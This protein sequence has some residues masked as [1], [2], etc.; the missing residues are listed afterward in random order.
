[1]LGYLN[2]PSPFDEDGWYNTHDVVEVDGPYIRILGRTT[3]LINVGGQKVYPSEVESALLE[4]DNVREAT[5]WG[6]PNPVTGQVVAARV[7]LARPEDQPSVR[8]A[9]PPLLSG[10]AGRLQDSRSWSRSSR[11]TITA[12]AS[13]RCGRTRR[14]PASSRRRE[15]TGPESH[16][17]NNRSC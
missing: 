9:H 16:R 13:R 12:S 14:W 3:E 5:V 8:A 2:A 15:R 11:A 17:W 1:M 6:E 4:M 10:P 7:T